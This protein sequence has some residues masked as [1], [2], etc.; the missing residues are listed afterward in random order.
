MVMNCIRLR[1][2]HISVPCIPWH[3]RSGTTPVCWHMFR[4]AHMGTIN[5][6]VINRWGGCECVR[7]CHLI[8]T[9]P[10]HCLIIIIPVEEGFKVGQ[11]RETL[12][13]WSGF[14]ISELQFLAISITII[15]IVII[16][17]QSRA[18]SVVAPTVWN[19][20]PPA[21]RLLPRTLSDTFYNQ[22]K[23][24]LFDRAGVGSTS[25]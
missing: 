10:R 7:E 18:C 25:E 15:V 17:I 19:G 14:N 6:H 20:L 11:N 4:C 5:L 2:F 23:T 9:L 1:S 3:N 21:L 16:I 24:V 12:S 22:L 8:F 13:N